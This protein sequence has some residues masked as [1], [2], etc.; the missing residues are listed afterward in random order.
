MDT[1]DR[2][3]VAGPLTWEPPAPQRSRRWLA[4]PLI[5]AVIGAL[6]IASATLSIPYYRLAPGSAPDVNDL[7]SAPSNAHYPPKGHIL[8]VTVQL[9]PAHPLD[10]AESWFDHDVKV[11]KEELIIGKQQP[12]QFNRANVQ[13]MADSKQA[14]IVVALRRLG[15]PVAERGQ[16]ALIDEVVTGKGFPAEGH[17]QVGEVITGVDGQTVHT[18]EDATAL[19]QKHKPGDTASVEVQAATGDN[20][21]RIER[22]TMAKGDQGK[23]VLGVVLQTYKL[24]FDM[25]LN[26]KIDSSNIGGP[27]AGLAFTLG[28]LDELT[29][30]ELTGGG[31]VAATGTIDLDGTVGDVGGVAQKTAAVIHAGAKYFLVPPGEYQEARHRAGKHLKVVKV[32]T[33][34]Q[35]LAALAQL[36]GNVQ[37][38][39][40]KPANPPG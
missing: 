27:S 32:A 21:S 33:L 2:M 28:V 12:Q 8:M 31:K 9:S 17:L 6:L 7:I 19:L 14:A 16:G 30:G 11:V 37:A 13:E 22:L 34:D 38:L 25:P 35:A 39:G 20:A 24:S 1:I 5:G 40:P 36:G 4:A 15:Y 23:A 29:P 18:V 10:V 3:V 26:V